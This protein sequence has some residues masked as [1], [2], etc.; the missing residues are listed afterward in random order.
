MQ[1]L[2]TSR[3]QGFTLIE[4]MIVVAII[5]VL[6]S[7]A[8]PS[9]LQYQARS[10]RSEAYSNLAEI[11]RSQTA[12]QAERNSFVSSGN[13][14]PQ[15]EVP[16]TLK[17][18][19]NAGAQAAFADLGWIPEGAVFYDY[20]TFTSATPGAG[21]SECESCFTATAVGDVDG[22][23]VPTQI[24]YVRQGPNDSGALITCLD[25]VFNLGAPVVDGVEVYDTVTPRSN[26]N[27]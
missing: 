1:I 8:I 19:W 4:L 23:G 22:N 3:K 17:R 6:A 26:S 24:Q 18:A 25:P 15:P 14:H 27:F 16:S 9:F 5:G 2:R 13:F 20:G 11:A 7:I 21:C 12:H 10:R